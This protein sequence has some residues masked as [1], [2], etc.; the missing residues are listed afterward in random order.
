MENAGEE[1]LAFG[2]YNDNS[3]VNLT[4]VDVRVD[5]HNKL[6]KETFAKD[7]SIKIVNGRCKIE[8]NDK[9]VERELVFKFGQ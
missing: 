6:D 1:A 5:V 2:G 8:V 3:E 9:E 4:S 7:E